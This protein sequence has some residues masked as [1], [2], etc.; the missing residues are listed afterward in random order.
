MAH[1]R[2]KSTASQRSDQEPTK[3]P[4]KKKESDKSR[5]STQA[6]PIRIVSDRSAVN[7][8]KEKKTEKS[9]KNLRYYSNT[10][11][12]TQSDIHTLAHS[13]G[14]VGS[15][16]EIRRPRIK[17]PHRQREIAAEAS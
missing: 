16:P 8:R 12:L 11:L 9:T 2:K 14:P 10:S 3:M 1:K 4:E 6:L 15:T 17:R 7:H 5:V 13:E